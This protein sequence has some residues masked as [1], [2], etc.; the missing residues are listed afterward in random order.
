M[1]PRPGL[2]GSPAPLHNNRGGAAD[3]SQA[4]WAGG[5]APIHNNRTTPPRGLGNPWSG[6][7]YPVMPENS[8]GNATERRRPAGQICNP[9]QRRP[10]PAAAT[11][12]ARIL[13]QNSRPA[14]PPSADA[15]RS[16]AANAAPISSADV[17]PTRAPRS[18][19]AIE[20]RGLHK[21]Y[22]SRKVLHG[23]DLKIETGEIFAL[24]GP[25]GAG[26]TT[27]IEILEGYRDRDSGDVQVLGEDPATAG[28]ELRARIG[29]VLQSSAVY[30]QLSVCRD[31]QALRR[32]L[33]QPA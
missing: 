19:R 7:T 4:V 17:E 33:H 9:R 15:P 29:I 3:I 32:L 5:P 10:P 24:L 21:S 22:G 2:A 27:T 14:P 16:P 6:Q 31:P 13:G 23:L 30:P 18:V 12:A 11:A 25:N 26:K 28:P 20:V 8:K 1:G